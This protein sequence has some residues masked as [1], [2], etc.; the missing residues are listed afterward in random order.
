MPL[1]DGPLVFIVFGFFVQTRALYLRG[2]EVHGCPLGNTLERVQ[3]IL[4]S[5][6]LTYLILRVLWRLNLL[7]FV[8]GYLQLQ[9]YLVLAFPVLISPIG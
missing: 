7:H 8:P 3:F 9:G 5:L 1:K 6:I 4:W 2:L